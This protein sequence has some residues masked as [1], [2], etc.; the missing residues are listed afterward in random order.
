MKLC[1]VLS[2]EIVAG[3]LA[4]HSSHN[5]HPRPDPLVKRTHRV[6]KGSMPTLTIAPPESN[7]GWDVPRTPKSSCFCM[8]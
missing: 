3:L 6:S 5:A 7:R 1:E 8:G 2:P 4:M